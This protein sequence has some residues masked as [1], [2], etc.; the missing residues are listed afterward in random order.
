MTVQVMR[1]VLEGARPSLELVGGDAPAR[2]VDLMTQC[3]NHD[4]NT[5]P[6]FKQVAT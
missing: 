6:S 4:P 2:Y 1:L 3:W 5:R